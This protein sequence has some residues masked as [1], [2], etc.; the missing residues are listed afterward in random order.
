M[1]DVPK[2]KA[3]S[4]ELKKASSDSK[5]KAFGSI[6]F[7]DTIKINGLRIIEG[8]K[9]LFVS[10]PARQIKN[11]WIAYMSFTEEKSDTRNKLHNW[12]IAQYKEGNFAESKPR[13]SN[14]GGGYS[15]NAPTN[16][17]DDDLPF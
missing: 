15:N 1:S 10:W 13:S 16:D 12:I 5:V 11:E 7:N 3:T 2:L 9:G 8:S 17:D 6:T 14:S 4:L